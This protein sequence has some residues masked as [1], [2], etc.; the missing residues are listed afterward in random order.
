MLFQEAPTSELI[1]DGWMDALSFGTSNLADNPTDTLGGLSYFDLDIPSPLM[2]FPSEERRSPERNTFLTTTQ[3]HNASVIQAPG[4]SAQ[5][6]E[7]DTHLPIRLIS[8]DTLTCNSS[9]LLQPIA[10]DEKGDATGEGGQADWQKSNRMQTT[11]L[12]SEVSSC[13]D[14][15][16]ALSS[17]NQLELQM[18]PKS[19]TLEDLE[20]LFDYPMEKASEKLGIGPTTMKKICRKVGISRWPYRHR[21]SLQKMRAKVINVCL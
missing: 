17:G 13:T 20:P 11:S 2:L 21:Q 15:V 7:E 4:R 3:G 18:D 5:A 12:S 1:D 9:Q 8:L 16:P 10:A 14:G 19:I 6:G